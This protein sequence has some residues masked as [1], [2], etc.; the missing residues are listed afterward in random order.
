MTVKECLSAFDTKQVQEPVF[1]TKNSPLFFE[2]ETETSRNE[3]I[4]TR[5]NGG[6]QRY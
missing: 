4:Q 3:G 2:T 6:L 5:Q 1:G